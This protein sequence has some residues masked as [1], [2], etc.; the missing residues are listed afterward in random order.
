MA[1]LRY[2]PLLDDWVMVSASRAK[3]PDMPK[4]FCPFDPG[5]GKVP[6]DYDVLCYAN[7]FP[8]LSKTPPPA[9]EEYCSNSTLYK[10]AP[11]YGNCDVILYSPNHYRRL[12]ELP[13]EHICKLVN[14]WKN[15]TAELASD[16]NIKYVFPFENNGKEVGTTMPHPH[17]QIYSYSKMPLRLRLELENAEAHYRKSGQN[18]FKS[19]LQEEKTYGKRVIMENEYFCVVLPFFCEYP[20]GCYILSKKHYASMLDFD[21]EAVTAFADILQKLLGT[22]DCLFDRAFPYMMGIYQVPFNS[23][24]TYPEAEQYYEFHVKF[25]PPLR[26]A[27]AIKWCASSETAAWVHGNPR[28]VEETAIELQAAYQKYLSIKD[29]TPAQ[30]MDRLS[31]KELEESLVRRFESR[32]QLKPQ[33]YFAPSRIN[34]IGEHIDYNGGKVLPAAIEIGTYVAIAP[35]GIDKIRLKSLNLEEEGKI[36]LDD[37]DFDKKRSWMNYVT[38]ILKYFQEASY[39]I[40]GFDL[41]VYGNIPNGAGLSSSA[42]LEL[43]V[44]TALNELFNEGRIPVLELIKIG[45]KVENLH[46]GLKSGI[47]D[48]FAIGAGAKNKAIYLDTSSLEYKYVDA[49]FKNA[50]FIIMN[51]NQRRELA[52]SKYNERRA[53]CELALALINEA[54]LL[55]RKL[56]N[57]CEID[58]YAELAKVKEYLHHLAADK[59][60][61]G[62]KALASLS[63]AAYELAL[64]HGFNLSLDCD[65]AVLAKRVEHVVCENLRVQMMMEALKNGENVTIGELLNQSHQSLRD[66]YEVTGKALDSITAAAVDYEYCYGARMTGAGFGGCAIALVDEAHIEEFKMIVAKRYAEECGNKAEFFISACAD[67]PR[68]LIDNKY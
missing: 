13:L 35:N 41:L 12:Y 1:E 30:V 55:N 36:A 51:T 40:G 22:F 2:N 25:F 39:N 5:S 56:Q 67:G 8:I 10:T 7:D 58:S 33:L 6:E 9:D 46:F 28:K 34:I 15:R 62:A 11:S 50:K 60:V 63:D 4:D 57:L 44:A 20:Y 27:N 17:G 43:A 48:Q 45:K 14:L 18:I 19:I 59:E 53:E 66:L 65:L 52:D 54:L 31:G 21:N 3:R 49:D 64:Q 68:R 16:S 38:G 23:A 32:Y 61:A 47:M 42:S 26:S 24:D 37:L 29:L